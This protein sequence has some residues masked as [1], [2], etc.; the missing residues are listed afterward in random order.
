VADSYSVATVPIEPS[1]PG[2]AAEFLSCGGLREIGQR[3]PMEKG[4]GA[5]GRGLG[6]SKLRARVSEFIPRAQACGPSRF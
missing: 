2:P 3:H 4:P 5:G 6:R 1:R